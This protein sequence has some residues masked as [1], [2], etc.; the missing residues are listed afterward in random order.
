VKSKCNVQL[1]CSCGR[2]SG[3]IALVPRQVGIVAI[4]N[5]VATQRKAKGDK[6]NNHG[7]ENPNIG[8]NFNPMAKAHHHDGP[9]SGTAQQL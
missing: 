3:R 5:V 1:S 4:I 2:L 6:R 9:H 8:H 7:T